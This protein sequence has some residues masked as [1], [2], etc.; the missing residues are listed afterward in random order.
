MGRTGPCRTPSRYGRSID[1]FEIAAES[2]FVAAGRFAARF[3]LD[4]GAEAGW[5]LS[6][7]SFVFELETVGGSVLAGQFA[8]AVGVGGVGRFQLAFLGLLIVRARAAFG[9]AAFLG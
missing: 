9:R 8:A 4:G 7:P 2:L 3:G 1:A 5:K 6:K